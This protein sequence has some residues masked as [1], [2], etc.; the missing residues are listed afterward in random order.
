M[1]KTYDNPTRQTYLPLPILSKNWEL[2]D[3]GKDLKNGERYGW[4][5]PKEIIVNDNGFIAN[6][7]GRNNLYDA[8]VYDPDGQSVHVMPGDP[9]VA[10]CNGVMQ[11]H[12]AS[13]EAAYEY[14]DWALTTA[15]YEY[16][17]GFCWLAK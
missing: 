13:L 10:H 3:L 15:T 9:A 2:T 8:K 5:R 7:F 4:M 16:L 6:I 17:M 1:T 11:L 14:A 12:N